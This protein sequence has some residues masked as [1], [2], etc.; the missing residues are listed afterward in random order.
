MNLEN[1]QQNKN[2]I[3]PYVTISFAKEKFVNIGQKAFCKMMT[4]IVK[5]QY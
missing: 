4:V 3:Q 1:K 2:V 5:I